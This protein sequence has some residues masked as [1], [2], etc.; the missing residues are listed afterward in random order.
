MPAEMSIFGAMDKRGDR[1]YPAGMSKTLEALLHCRL[2]V[3][4]HISAAQGVTMEANRFRNLLQ[5]ETET[6]AVG[7][8]RVTVPWHLAGVA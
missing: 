5:E 7:R 2:D 3:R 4:K 6:A 8:Q 1:V